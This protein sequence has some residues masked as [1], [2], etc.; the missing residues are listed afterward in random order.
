MMETDLY[1][2]PVFAVTSKELGGIGFWA[3]KWYA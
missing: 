3:G 2:T 1:N